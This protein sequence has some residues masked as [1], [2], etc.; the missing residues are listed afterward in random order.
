MLKREEEHAK[1][2]G[3]RF[4]KTEAANRLQKFAEFEV[5]WFIVK[6]EIEK[7]ENIAV[8]DDDIKEL[9]QKDMEKTGLPEDKLMQYYK[10]SNIT[11]KMLDKKLFTFLNEKNTITKVDP[12]IYSTNVQKDKE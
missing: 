12:A 7:K 9:V 2:D 5:K 11:E 8:S 1:K 6:A 3:H 4:D 10:S